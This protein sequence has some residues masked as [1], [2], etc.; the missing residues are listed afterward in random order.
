MQERRVATNTHYFSDCHIAAFCMSPW[1]EDR[2][3][4]REIMK[5]LEDKSEKE[6][7]TNVHK[8]G[9]I[10]SL[11]PSDKKALVN[12]YKTGWGFKAEKDLDVNDTRVVEK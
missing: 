1:T 5:R 8:D 11:M 3:L 10:L 6:I 4:G 12:M 7:E 2:R 9:Y